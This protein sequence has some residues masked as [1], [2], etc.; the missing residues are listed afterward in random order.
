MDCTVTHL[1]Y[2]DTFQFSDLVLDYLNQIPELNSFF[3]HTPDIDGIRAAIE[4]RRNFPTD[5][6]R[7]A[8]IFNEQYKV[9]DPSEKQKFHIR[10]LI[11]DNCFTICTAHQPNIFTGY[12]YTIYKTAH[13]IRIAEDLKKEFP[14]L[15]FVPVFYIGS[16]DND[17]DELGQIHINGMKMTW[18]TTQTGAVGRMFVDKDLVKIKEDIKRQMA[19]YPFGRELAVML[20]KA[21]HEGKTI[22]EATSILLNSLF[23]SHGLLVLQPDNKELK[24]TMISIFSDDLFDN[25]SH[26]LVEKNNAALAEKYKVQVNPREINLFYLV[27]DRRDRIVLK[28]GRFYAEGSANSFTPEE[29]KD[30]LKNHPENFSP[31]VVLRGLYQEII[32]PNIAFV[33]GGSEIAYWLELKQ[34]FQHYKVPY[35]VLIL[36]NSFVIYNETQKSRISKLGWEISDLFKPDLDL[37]NGYVKEHS[38]KKLGVDEEIEETKEIYQKLKEAAEEIDITLGQH[39]AA[40]E[41]RTIKDLK[42]LEKKLIRAEKRNFEVQ[43]R[44]LHKLKEE[45][46]PKNGLQERVEN[47]IPFY[48]TYGQQFIDCIVEKS[49][50]FNQEFGIMLLID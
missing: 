32:L 19:S 14:D 3:A 2:R 4:E 45:L 6:N 7:I 16:E 35:P 21:Y 46:F 27:G 42:E 11:H 37:M 20:D 24:Q 22:A 30:E 41:H 29:M 26:S 48:A 23:R 17:L 31:N 43:Q 40:L 15:N 44:Q 25:T 28:D 12:L 33:G 13:I 8:A 10:S 38:K 9:A 34:V 47:F 18:K 49:G 36:R 50:S 1:P 39:I 5:R